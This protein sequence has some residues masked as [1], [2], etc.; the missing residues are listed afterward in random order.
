MAR[1]IEEGNIP[2]EREYTK[3]CP[4]C[5]T[6]FAASEREF[7]RQEPHRWNYL[8]QDSPNYRIRC[9]FCYKIIAFRSLD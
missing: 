6:L 2:P 9:P 5:K 7:H 1:I 4:S 3:R 8:T